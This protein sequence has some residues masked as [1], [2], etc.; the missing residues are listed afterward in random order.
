MGLRCITDGKPVTVYRQDK[1]SQNGVSYTQY[2]LGI[3]SKDKDGNWLSGYI[4]CTFKKGTD[5]PHKSK[6]E[7]SNSFYTINEYNGKKY[8]KLFVLDFQIVESGLAQTRPK[9]MNM[10]WMNVEDFADVENIFV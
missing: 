10:E 1:T 8:Y 4:D 3:S 9:E 6:I 5:I 2:S 7:I